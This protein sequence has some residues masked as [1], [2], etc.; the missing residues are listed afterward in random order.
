MITQETRRESYRK[1]LSKCGPR[2]R[3]ILD[4]LANDGPCTANELAESFYELGDTP[5]FNRNYVHPRLN[6]LVLM[7]KV[8]VI[9]KR[10]D[11]MTD[12]T[13]AIYR[14]KEGQ[15]WLALAIFGI[16]GAYWEREE[17]KC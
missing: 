6:E 17:R 16:S 9:G 15:A 4:R 8:E 14:V 3:L 2:H 12:R 13:C 7:Q 5:Y 11:D 10:H 1:I